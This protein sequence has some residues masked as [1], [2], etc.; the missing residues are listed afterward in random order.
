MN[1]YAVKKGDRRVRRS[2]FS[3]NDF[4]LLLASVAFCVALI[5]LIRILPPDI[6]IEVNELSIRATWLLVILIS[7]VDLVIFS[8]HKKLTL[9]APTRRI[10]DAAARIGKGD[11][12]VRIKPFHKKYFKNEFDVIIEDLNS[13]AAEL[14]GVETMKKDFIAN[15]SHELKTPLAVI[16]NYVTLLQTTEPDAEKQAEYTKAIAD[17]TRRLNMLISNILKLNKLESQQIFPENDVFDLGEQLCEALLGFD[18][19]MEEKQQELQV[20]LEE[21]VVIHGDEELLMHIWDNLISNAVKF[22]PEG[23]TLTVSLRKG[24]K[25]AIVKVAD[26]GCGMTKEEQSHIFEKFY[27]SDNS[28]SVQGNGLGLSL[29]KRIVDVSG[30]IIDVESEPGQG[31]V[32]TVR[33]PLEP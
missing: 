25:Y 18:H 20:D 2:V 21:D 24:K 12:S 27:Q 4:L 28:H 19:R 16:S 7:A 3:V 1:R 23:G 11:F 15:V 5:W 33:L 13:M 6:D 10:L 9:E 17:A 32:F 26:N 31:S 8:L 29:V 30:G 14:T 22:T